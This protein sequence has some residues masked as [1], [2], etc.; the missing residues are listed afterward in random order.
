[1]NIF[2]FLISLYKAR[3]GTFTNDEF[4]SLCVLYSNV[5]GL[6]SH[7]RKKSVSAVLSVFFSHRTPTLGQL[8]AV[9]GSG[10]VRYLYLRNISPKR[11]LT[12]EEEQ[13]FATLM[14]FGPVFRFPRKLGDVAVNLL[15]ES[16]DIR[17]IAKYVSDY[18][19]SEKFELELIERYEMQKPYASPNNYS[20]PDYAYALKQY[21]SQCKQPKCQ[22][23]CVQ[24]K[25]LTLCD[26]EMLEGL[27]ASQNMCENALDD[28]SIRELIT[29]GYKKSLRAL[30]MH[31]F[32]KSVELQ[33]YLLNT[34]PEL[35]WELEISK[36]RHALCPLEKETQEFWGIEAPNFTEYKIIEDSITA[37]DQVDRIIEGVVQSR[38][39]KGIATPYFCA[40]A[41][42]EYPYLGESA[43]MCVRSFAEKYLKQA[44]SGK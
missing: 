20:K 3:F 17:R 18:A 8:N 4:R 25:L 33:R 11:Q 29:K 22:T 9:Y 41:S 43:Y 12:P 37:D 16:G 27:C 40:W 34:L 5:N 32:I 31:S 15:F 24:K 19:L 13:Y 30:L 35:K 39:S 23:A 26:D 38:I 21:L 7:D 1:M 36:V 42:G 2:K 14:D 44:K 28:V 10:D 6:F